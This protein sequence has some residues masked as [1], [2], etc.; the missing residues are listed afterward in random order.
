MTRFLRTMR[1]L[2]AILFIA[3]VL[4][5]CWQTIDIYFDGTTA[6]SAGD[7]SMYRVDD[8]RARLRALAAPLIAF[9]AVSGLTLILHVA[10]PEKALSGRFR[11]ARVYSS[12]KTPPLKG[13]NKLRGLILC[14]TIAFILLGVMNGGAYD[15]LVKAI[16][17]CTE[18]IGLG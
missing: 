14:I 7:I 6:A 12:N 10:A 4:L 18:C 8:L 16:N 13:Q 11:E 9:A 1:N 17:I 3:V 2:T 15:V 5:L